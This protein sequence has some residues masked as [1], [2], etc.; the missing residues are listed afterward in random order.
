MAISTSNLIAG[1][2]FA[3]A[4]T[5]AWAFNFVA[6][7]VTGA[8]SLYDLTAVRF[9]FAGSLGAASLLF[10]SS[11]RRQLRASQQWL[12]A[13]LGAIGYLGYGSCIAAG[14]A[15]GGPVLTPALIGTV[16]VLLAVTGNV[17]ERAMPW[18]KLVMP[19]ALIGAGLWLVNIGIWAQPL[20]DSQ[21][22]P[23]AIFFSLGAIALWI[24]F[25]VL[26]KRAM[27][28]IPECTTAVWTGLMMAGA[29]M[30]TLGVVPV[31]YWLGLFELPVLGFGLAAASQLYSWALIIALTSSVAGAWAWNAAT[32]RLPVA[33]SGQLIALESLFATGLALIFTG[34]PPT[35]A[36]SAGLLIVLLGTSLGIHAALGVEHGR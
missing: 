28:G 17:R 14:V 4:A 29:G 20:G 25:S 23:L 24:A 7:Y 12:A 34:R 1:V 26:N 16:P 19:L 36:E 9:L 31:I 3:V 11:Q 6:P 35:L 8:Y 33:L 18:R 13:G 30:A 32:R 2:V 21:S 10:Y 22:I 27:A 5:L 15:L